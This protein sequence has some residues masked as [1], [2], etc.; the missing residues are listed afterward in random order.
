MAAG[1]EGERPLTYGTGA[2]AHAARD[3][4]ERDTSLRLELEDPQVHARP[5]VGGRGQRA[6]LTGVG[7]RPV[8]ARATPPDARD[9]QGRSRGEPRA[10]GRP[11]GPA[12][13]PE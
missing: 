9:D 12:P 1:V 7:A 3:A 4:M 13:P 5:A 2:G 8:G 6:R 11:L 10:R